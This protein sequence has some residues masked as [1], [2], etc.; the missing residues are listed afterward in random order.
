MPKTLA[1]KV[2]DA[3]VVRSAAGEPDLRALPVELVDRLVDGLRGAGPHAAAAVEHAVDG[4]LADARLPGDLP[5]RIRMSH[6]Q[7][8][9]GLM[10][11][12]SRTEATAPRVL[13]DSWRCE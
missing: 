13:N 4:G 3:H 6:A 7:K 12:W 11:A 10:R 8:R 5:D 9:D 2:Y 1:E